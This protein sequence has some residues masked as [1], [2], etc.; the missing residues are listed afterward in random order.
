M[1]IDPISILLNI[2]SKLIDNLFPDPAQKAAAQLELFKLQQSGMLAELAATTELAKGQQAVNL[3]D[4]QSGNLF[5]SGWRPFVGWTCG[6]GFFAKFVGGPFLFTVA[7][8]FGYA[9]VLPPIDLTEMLPLLVG[10][11][12]LGAYRTYEKTR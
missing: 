6:M 7:P 3:A 8:F 10:M 5:Q 9:V 4:A 2:G 1:G 11:L 12:G